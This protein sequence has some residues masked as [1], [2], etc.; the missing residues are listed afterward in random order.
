MGCE[1]QTLYTLGKWAANEKVAWGIWVE[2]K[3]DA[4]ANMTNTL[5]VG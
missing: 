5:V 2:I 1:S 3:W 4:I